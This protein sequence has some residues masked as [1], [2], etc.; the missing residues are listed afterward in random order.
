MLNE[1]EIIR[2]NF[3]LVHYNVQSALH[4]L[5]ILE[6][7]LSNFDVISFSETW[8]NKDVNNSDIILNNYGVRF[9]NDRDNDAH[10]GVA[11]DV[12]NNIPCLRR[13][14]FEIFNVK[15]VWIEIRLNRKRLLVGIFYRPLIL[16]RQS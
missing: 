2:N 3:S 15:S 12:K 6:S 9:R 13:P 10:G 11:G 4:K 7:E 1:S 16:I 8:F 14:E 5:D